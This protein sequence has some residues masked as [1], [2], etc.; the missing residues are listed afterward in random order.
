MEL[1]DRMKRRGFSAESFYRTYRDMCSPPMRFLGS[2]ESGDVWFSR[3]FDPILVCVGATTLLV[4]YYPSSWSRNKTVAYFNDS[5]QWLEGGTADPPHP[6]GGIKFAAREESGSIIIR[7]YI[8]GDWA[9]YVNNLPL[10]TC[11]RGTPRTD[12]STQI[13]NEIL[14]EWLE[15]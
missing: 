12:E 13:E 6:N 1:D 14:H 9:G 2:I 11:T 10:E 7:E 4:M 3:H 5:F 8:H 15:K